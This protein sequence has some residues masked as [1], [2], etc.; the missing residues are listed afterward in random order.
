MKTIRKKI[1][2]LFNE[3]KTGSVFFTVVDG[4]SKGNG[5]TN[6]AYYSYKTWW[7]KPGHDK[8]IVKHQ[9]KK[10]F[11]EPRTNNQ[12]E[13]LAL[14]AVLESALVGLTQI[15]GNHHI[16]IASDSELL[17]NIVTGVKGVRNASLQDL[18]EQ[19]SLI[20]DGLDMTGITTDIQWMSNTK[21]KAILGH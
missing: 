7:E 17:V 14:L 3:R 5:S 21:V 6:D 18:Y 16:H 8:P 1:M 13:F 9:P 2:S 12:A 20:V 11:A 15:G 10:S 4:G 19:I